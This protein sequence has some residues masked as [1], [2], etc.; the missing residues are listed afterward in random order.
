MK[1]YRR[2]E[3]VCAV[4]WLLKLNSCTRPSVLHPHFHKITASVR[5]LRQRIGRMSRVRRER[6]R[7][8]ASVAVRKVFLFTSSPSLIGQFETVSEKL[9]AFVTLLLLRSMGYT[10]LH[11]MGVRRRQLGFMGPAAHRLGRSPKV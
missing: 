4:F 6:E 8:R 2:E 7:G 3:V 1:V 11:T 10:V 5:F 9:A